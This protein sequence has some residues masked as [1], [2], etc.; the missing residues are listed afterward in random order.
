M[1]LL[2]TLVDVN[3]YRFS[4]STHTHTLK[5][6]IKRDFVPISTVVLPISAVH[7]NFC[8]AGIWIPCFPYQSCMTRNTGKCTW[9]ICA[10]TMLHPCLKPLPFCAVSFPRVWVWPCM[11]LDCGQGG[12]WREMKCTKATK[13]LETKKKQAKVYLIGSEKKSIRCSSMCVNSAFIL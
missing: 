12:F 11:V 4:S 10:A 2:V 1:T 6:S 8:L 13:A 3:S 7:F 9:S 5:T